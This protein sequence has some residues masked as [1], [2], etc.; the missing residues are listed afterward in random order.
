VSGGSSGAVVV[1]G[2]ASGIGEAVARRLAADG[3]AV[4]VLD[5]NADGATRVADDIGGLALVA[6]VADSAAL[7]AALDRA[8]EQFGG[9]RGL[10]N[11]AGVGNL[12]PLEAYTD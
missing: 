1:T 5:R 4:G 2:A 8:A 10:V 6:D 7:D 12:K 3:V 11:N 9:L